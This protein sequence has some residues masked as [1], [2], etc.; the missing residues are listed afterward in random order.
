MLSPD[1][2]SNPTPS[3]VGRLLGNDK[4]R[5]TRC[6][7]DFVRRPFESLE[8]VQRLGLIVILYV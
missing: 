6:A 2:Q 8:Y 5:L 3:L 1:F 7:M 4:P